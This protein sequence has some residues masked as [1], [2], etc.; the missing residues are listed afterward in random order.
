MPQIYLRKELY[1]K[2]VKLGKD[3]SKFVNDHVEIALEELKEG[4]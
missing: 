4:Q 1:D 3:P 2:I